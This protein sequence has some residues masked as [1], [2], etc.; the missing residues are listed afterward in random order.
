MTC[1]PPIRPL[2]RSDAPSGARG[3]EAEGLRQRTAAGNICEG[4]WQ[5]AAA[6]EAR[7]GKGYRILAGLSWSVLLTAARL[8]TL[9]VP[10]HGAGV[11]L[12]LLSEEVAPGAPT[13]PGW[14]CRK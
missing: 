7:S 9:R 1:R 11:S 2:Y 14:D 3:A 6:R 5:S 10:G 13:F 4:V 8:K 12:E